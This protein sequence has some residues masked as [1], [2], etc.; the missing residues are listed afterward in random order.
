MQYVVFNLT[1]GE[2]VKW[3]E[4]QEENLSLQAG[5]GERALATSS[6]S[7]EGNKLIVWEEVKKERDAR[8]NGGA[9]TSFGVVDSDEISRTNISGATIAALVAKQSNTPF[10]ITWTMKDNSTA[11]L[12]SDQMIQLGIEVVQ[13]INQMHSVARNYRTAIESAQNMAE[14]LAI[15]VT[16]NW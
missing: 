8:I 10:S 9:P 6:L 2:P 15:D 14:L 4:T 12:N 5:P 16:E 3:G 13:Y 11:S 7:V 1:T